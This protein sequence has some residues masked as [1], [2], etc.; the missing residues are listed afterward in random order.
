[1]KLI[2]TSRYYY[3]YSS[4]ENV[5][6]TVD[7]NWYGKILSDD[8]SN[9][10]YSKDVVDYFEEEIGSCFDDCIIIVDCHRRP[11]FPINTIKSFD[12]Y[13]NAYKG[14]DSKYKILKYVTI[15]I[16]IRENEDLSH[17]LEAKEKLE[18]SEMNCFDG[19]EYYAIRDIV[20]D[21]LKDNG[22]YTYYDYIAVYDKMYDTLGED[23]ISS[24]QNMSYYRIKTS[25]I[26]Q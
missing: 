4:N 10:I 18:K 25:E 1:M 21:A 3:L 15:D 14:L 11:Q 24:F 26:E 16:Y 2:D 5:Y 13:I 20:F 12:E 17:V 6:A 19:F 7:S 23:N 9:Y 22:V 8:Y